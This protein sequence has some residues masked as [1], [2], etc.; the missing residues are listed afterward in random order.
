M[1]CIAVTLPAAVI[2]CLSLTSWLLLL[3]GILWALFLH[4]RIMMCMKKA[5]DDMVPVL[6]S[7]TLDGS[8]NI[9]MMF[10]NV[11]VLSIV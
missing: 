6:T 8:D 2:F 10:N 7:N 11:S 5:I 9:S 4:W 1:T 3:G